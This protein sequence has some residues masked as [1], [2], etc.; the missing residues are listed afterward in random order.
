VGLAI[1]RSGRLDFGSFM[2][3]DDEQRARILRDAFET[4]KRLQ[5]R[6]RAETF[7]VSEEV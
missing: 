6:A 3:M 7:S 1:A 2:V 4:L 5:E